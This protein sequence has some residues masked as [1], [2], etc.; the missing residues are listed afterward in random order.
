LQRFNVERQVGRI[1]RID[2]TIALVMAAAVGVDDARFTKLRLQRLAEID[3]N[4]LRRL[5]KFRVRGWIRT[6]QN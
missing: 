1:R 2:S 5:R 3:A 6:N 4:D